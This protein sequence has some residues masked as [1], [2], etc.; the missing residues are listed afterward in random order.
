MTTFISVLGGFCFLMCAFYLVKDREKAEAYT[1]TQDD[2]TSLLGSVASQHFSPVP[3]KSQA[4]DSDDD[5]DDDKL[6]GIDA[7]DPTQSEREALIVPVDVHTVS[8]IPEPN[9]HVI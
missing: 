7:V 6:I 2:D 1:R 8:P 3:I 9:N 5:D 4:Q